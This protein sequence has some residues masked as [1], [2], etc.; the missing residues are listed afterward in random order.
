M[1]RGKG[2]LFT[3]QET[4]QGELAN[5]IGKIGSESLNT[6]HTES[7]GNDHI[8]GCELPI[9]TY[10][11]KADK[12]EDSLGLK[13]SAKRN[14]SESSPKTIDS[15]SKKRK[16]VKKYNKEATDVSRESCPYCATWMKSKEFDKHIA[17]CF[18]TEDGEIKRR[19][20]AKRSARV[21]ARVDRYS[22]ETY[23][24]RV[25]KYLRQNLH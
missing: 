3:E 23:S 1:G 18:K 13:L 21:I 7:S 11:L 10:K 15:S 16:K 5:A 25:Y 24:E 12:L 17:K 6:E 9:I 19:E 22:P 14:I 8:Q 2:E 4:L 20:Q